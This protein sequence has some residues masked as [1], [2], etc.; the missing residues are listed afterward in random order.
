[1]AGLLSE[2]A[3]GFLKSCNYTT[4]KHEERTGLIALAKELYP[5][6]QVEEEDEE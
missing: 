4:K 1:M 3:L 5:N 6:T 2:Q